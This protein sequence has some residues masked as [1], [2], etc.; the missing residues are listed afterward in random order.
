MSAEL[1]KSI[2]V[3]EASGR[4]FGKRG[5]VIAVASL[6]AIGAG[7]AAAYF[8]APDL[9]LTGVHIPVEVLAQFVN[10]ANDG[11]PFRSALA[12]LNNVSPIMSQVLLI[13]AVI[14]GGIKAFMSGKMTEA[15]APVVAAVIL[16]IA[17]KFT[18]A[19]L[20]GGDFDG[21]DSG[22]TAV[23]KFTAFAER[24]DVD[25]LRAALADAN[26]SAA[27]KDYVLAQT[28][29]VAAR[30]KGEAPDSAE[31]ARQV[32]DL[33]AALQQGTKIDVDPRTVYLLERHAL[34]GP[35]SPLAMQHGEQVSRRQVW[36][37]A[38]GAG[39]SV[40]GLG[41]LIIGLGSLGLAAVIMRRVK[42]LREILSPT[43]AVSA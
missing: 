3:L 37:N 4:R 14:A 19:N 21:G 43:K 8:L 32:R 40:V 26:A 11:P 24:A 27:A 20:S 23:E 29:L 35:K 16:L 17:V 42:R 36:G 6:V 12:S 41:G 5:T 1:T 10:Y 9:E 18:I 34:G 2:N 31:L 13:I 28:T 39:T 15:I 7:H 22:P 38:I 30:K 33:D 25:A